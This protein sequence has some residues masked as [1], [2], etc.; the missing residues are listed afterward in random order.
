[1]RNRSLKLG[2][3]GA[4]SAVTLAVPLLAAQ[5]A[6][7]DYAPSSSD[8]VGVGSD[9]LQYMVDF[10]ADG[11]GTGTTGYNQLGNKNKF[12]N[13]DATVDA[14]ARLAYGVDG[15]QSSQTTCTAGTGSTSGTGNGT[16]GG[17]LPCVLNPTVVLRSGLQPVQRPNGSGAGFN[18]LVQDVLN[19]THNINYSRSS[20]PRSPAA[21]IGNC[22]V[23]AANPCFD[24]IIIGNDTEPILTASTTNYPTNGLSDAELK[25]ILQQT[26]TAADPFV[27]GPNPHTGCVT[28]NELPSATFAAGAPN[29]ADTINVVVPQLGSGTRQ[30]FLD[31]AFGNPITTSTPALPT[32]NSC[33]STGEENDPTAVNDTPPLN[34]AP[35]TTPVPADNVVPMSTGRLNLFNGVNS[36]G[37]SDGLPSIGYFLDPS[38][39]YD[40]DTAACDTLT[41]ATT[42]SAALSTA[43]G[44][45]T[46]LPVNAT[47]AAI[48]ANTLLVV[49]DGA[50]HNQV[51]KTS[52]ASVSGV[53]SLPVFSLTPNFNYA[54][55]AAVDITPKPK[56]INTTTGLMTQPMTGVTPGDG[57]TLY[58]LTRPLY[59]YFRN[60]DIASTTPFQPG[61]TEN[62]LNSL[63]YDPCQTGAVGCQTIGGITYGPGGQP[64]IDVNNTGISDAGVT[65]VDPDAAGNFQLGGA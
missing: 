56:A 9:T 19:G 36:G 30:V 34:S 17:G 18:A 28:W 7:A 63:F 15:G 14:N 10:L 45:I 25:A 37:V 62:W 52:A 3:I 41:G 58:T 6:F 60:S 11:D 13:F 27:G 47:T 8:V 5:P 65:P 53:T 24:S 51:F 35:A 33:Y 23:S 64:F 12:V 43:G 61:S 48:P 16:A 38:C 46:A 54:I 40:V 20:A 26:T 29:T 49:T 4:V 2:L 32:T 22:G 50:T 1:M 55:G 21:I 44:A 42:L 31:T 39:A 59:V 57:G